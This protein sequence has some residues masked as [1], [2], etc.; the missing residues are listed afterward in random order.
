LSQYLPPPPNT[1]AA[2]PGYVPYGAMGAGGWPMAARPQPLRGL[3]LTLTILLPLAALLALALAFVHVDRASLIDDTF[4]D[5]GAGIDFAALQDLDDADDRVSA[6]T[7][8]YV[9]MVL[10]TGC[11]FIAWQFR[12]AK[13]A[14]AL[15]SRGGLGPGWAIGGWFIPVGSFVLPGLQLHQSSRPSDPAPRPGRPGRGRPIIIVWMVVWALSGLLFAIGSGMEPSEDDYLF[16]DLDQLVDDQ[17]SADRTTAAGAFLGAV[18]G[19]LAIAMVRQ[20]SL[21][22][23][24]AIDRHQAAV[25][26]APPPPSAPPPWGAPPPPPPTGAPPPPLP[27][28]PGS[29]EAP[30]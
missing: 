16:T 4:S 3:A 30:S 14:Q 22:Q 15:G 26:N 10:I 7:A 29:F 24:Q 17:T 2:P 25:T 1:G 28:P 27:S 20:L 11:V 5:G 9:V 18:A 21:L 12:H 8:F 19:G 13:N 6:V 23:T